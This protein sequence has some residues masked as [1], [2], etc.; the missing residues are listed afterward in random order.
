MN[1]LIVLP[2]AERVALGTRLDEP[3]G[4]V[5]LEACPG[6]SEWSAFVAVC[7]R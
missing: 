5:C 4:G 1:I 7:R 6:E 3:P 2:V